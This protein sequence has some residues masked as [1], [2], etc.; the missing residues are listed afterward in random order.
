MAKSDLE[1]YIKRDIH[2]EKGQ[3]AHPEVTGSVLGMISDKSFGGHDFVVTWWPISQ[4][5]EMV[6][7]T[8]FHDFDQYLMF[9][10]GDMSNML[11]LGGEVELTLGEQGGKLEKFVFTTATIVYVHAGLMHGPL[12]FKKV[13]N[14]LKPMLYNDI[15]FTT[16]NYKRLK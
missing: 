16:A 12:N 11:D 7:E 2:S 10:G 4:P 5:F 8:H 1:K 15:T 3:Q 9:M 13:N 14:P 6:K